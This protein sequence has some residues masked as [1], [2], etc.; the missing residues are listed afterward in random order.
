[1]MQTFLS[2]K[3][4]FWSFISMLLLVYVHGYNLNQTYLQSATMPGEAM[5][6]TSFVEYLLANGLLR[7]RIPMFFAIS[8][9]LFALGD[10][11]PYGKRVSKRLRT[12]G[13]PYLLWTAIAMATLYALPFLGADWAQ[14]VKNTY[15]APW[16]YPEFYTAKWWEYI[17]YFTFNSPVA[18]QLWFLRALL[19]V[20]L[21]YPGLR[22]LIETR[23]VGKVNVGY[24]LQIF[25]FVTLAIGY[26]VDMDL[27]S[28]VLSLIHPTLGFTVFHPEAILFFSIGIWFAK[29]PSGIP[30]KPVWGTPVWVW[31]ALWIGLCVGKTW[32]A[33]ALS[34]ELGWVGPVL[35]FMHKGSIL[36]GLLA[37]WYGM[38][39]LV[40]IC[41]QSKP[42]VWA[43]AFSFFIYALHEPLLHV[44]NQWVFLWAKDI[45]YYRITAYFGLCVG[46]TLFSI[47]VGWVLRTIAPPVYSILTGGRGMKTPATLEVKEK[48]QL[49]TT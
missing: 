36:A 26:L 11:A 15:L 3:F 13:L 19:F 22:W 8:G 27:G 17:V 25:F 14:A 41:M 4:R 21:A 37:A 16:D 6:A 1:M 48:H 2:H 49:V 38:D 39:G 9:Y 7:F 20:N 40:R 35:H 18:F 29:R 42:F 46:I 5:T 10:A 47:V 23:K 32:M 12:L 24:G 43:S 34:P 28:L 44:L 45:P 30:A 31:F 33:F